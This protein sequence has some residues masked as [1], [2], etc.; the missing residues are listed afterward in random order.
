MLRFQGI[1]NVVNIKF[2]TF[3]DFK[4]LLKFMNI[5]IPYSYDEKKI[6]EKFGINYVY[7]IDFV[8]SD[9]K[10]IRK[11]IMY[12]TNNLFSHKKFLLKIESEYYLQKY[13]IFNNL[14]NVI[15][16]CKFKKYKFLSIKKQH[17]DIIYYKHTVHTLIWILS[18]YLKFF[19]HNGLK[20]FINLTNVKNN[21]TQEYYR[22]KFNKYDN[23]FLLFD[24][25]LIYHFVFLNEL[26]TFPLTDDLKYFLSNINLISDKTNKYF[27]LYL[28]WYTLI[29]R[30]IG[31]DI[32]NKILLEYKITKTDFFSIDDE[33]SLKNIILF[34][35]Y[36]CKILF[37]TNKNN[38][39]CPICLNDIELTSPIHLCKNGHCSHLHC[40]IEEEKKYLLSAIKRINNANKPGLY[41]RQSKICCI[42]REDNINLRIDS[43]TDKFTTMTYIN[44]LNSG[45]LRHKNNDD[46]YFEMPVDLLICNYDKQFC[47]CVSDHKKKSFKKY[48]LKKFNYIKNILLNEE[49]KK[50][51]K[52]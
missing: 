47:H 19:S 29:E 51:C 43:E 38:I 35:L 45:L 30:I 8:I 50:I 52:I 49:Q 46:R 21:Q 1:R 37:N 39:C 36:K 10:N 42:C 2:K 31:S 44:I 23:T 41:N 40:I 26:F 27:T 11:I 3:N 16:K 25:N 6:K 48:L 32:L 15:K 20:E 33:I 5:I 18:S 24:T 17:F 13:T 9:I 22:K 28:K 7:A 34:I 4:K 12:Y 14:T